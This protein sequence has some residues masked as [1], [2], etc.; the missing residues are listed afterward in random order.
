MGLKSEP[1]GHRQGL[2][3]A[4]SAVLATV[5]KSIEALLNQVRPTF[6]AGP[7]VHGQELFAGCGQ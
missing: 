2:A 4:L 1:Q 5:D 7:W 3:I 6:A